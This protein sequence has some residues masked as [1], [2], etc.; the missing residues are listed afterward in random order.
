MWKSMILG[1]QELYGLSPI[2]HPEFVEIVVMFLEKGGKIGMVLTNEILKMVKQNIN[3]DS[4]APYFSSGSLA[5]Y[6]C[7]DMKVALTVTDTFVSVGLFMIDGVYDS[8]A[9]L[10][11]SSPDAI[12]WGRDLFEYYKEIAKLLV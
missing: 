11:S 12:R 5:L 6:R 1:S 9:D 10:V 7:E 4:L 8:S 3:F 2:F